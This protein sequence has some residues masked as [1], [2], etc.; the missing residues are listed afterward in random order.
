[1]HQVSLFAPCIV[2]QW[3]P[4]IGRSVVT[5]LSRIGCRSFFHKDQTCC[6]QLLY[7]A[8]HESQ[9]RKLARRFIE[10]F[11][12]D[13]VIVCPSGSCV[14]MVRSHYPL[15]FVNEPEWKKRAEAVAARVFELSEFLVDQVRI[16]DVGARFAGKA[17]YHE[18]C[19]LLYGLG[20]SKQPKALLKGVRDLELVE[21][22]G[23]DICCGFGGRFSIDYPEIS[24]AMAADKAQWFTES[25][26]DVL[27][28]GEP[29]CLLHLSGYMSRHHPEKKVMHLASFLAE[30]LKKAAG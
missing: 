6:G 3:L 21:M 13:P 9:A 27:V 5:L 20:V 15:L 19:S 11:E 17:A 28:M 18:S 22:E 24:T 2:D 7:N 1:M 4:D 30:N 23:S 8:G 16:T 25:G 26:A 10:I 12:N 29:G 14:Q